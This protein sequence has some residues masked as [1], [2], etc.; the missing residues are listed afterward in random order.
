[1]SVRSCACEAPKR[2]LRTNKAE[3]SRD[4]LACFLSAVADYAVLMRTTGSSLR[5]SHSRRRCRSRGRWR[6]DD[7]PRGVCVCVCVCVCACVRACVCV[8]ACVHMCM[9]VHD[10]CP[11]C[12]LSSPSSAYSHAHARG[13]TAHATHVAHAHTCTLPCRGFVVTV[14]H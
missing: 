11:C 13:G 14:R 1:M 5:L 7:C 6:L 2:G 3:W 8:C 4:G 12:V 10:L 9:C